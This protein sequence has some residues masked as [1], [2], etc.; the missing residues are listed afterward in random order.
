MR[1]GAGERRAGL[2]EQVGDRGR[3]LGGD[4]VADEGALG[5]A[6][7][8]AQPVDM[9]ETLGLGRECEVLPRLRVES[10]EVGE[11][12]TEGVGLARA[13]FV[14]LAQV[15]QLGAGVGVARVGLAVGADEG[16]DRRVGLV[17]HD[18][19]LLGAAQPPLV[20]LA[21]DDDEHL[22]QFTEDP[23]G[24]RAPADVGA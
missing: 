13:T 12:G 15:R 9:G 5:D 6:G 3:E 16:G 4:V 10:F 18:P 22:A 11:T 1:T 17:E 8:R 24:G 21:V 23:D 20:G 2:G 7:G 14:E 19:V